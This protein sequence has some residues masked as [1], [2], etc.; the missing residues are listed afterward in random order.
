MEQQRLA[1]AEKA[2]SE[3]KEESEEDKVAK[4]EKAAAELLKQEEREKQAK[5]G[6]KGVKKGFL[7]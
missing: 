3:I 6:F 5:Q 2:K 4:A 1:T 7:G